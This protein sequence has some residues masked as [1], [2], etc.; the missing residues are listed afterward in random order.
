[1]DSNN[2]NSFLKNENT[3]V[4]T[5]LND[6]INYFKEKLLKKSV[7]DEK[8]KILLYLYKDVN[9]SNFQ[10]LYEIEAI[11]DTGATKSCLPTTVLN[12]LYKECCAQTTV[13]YANNKS[14][15]KNVYRCYYWLPETKKMCFLVINVDSFLININLINKMN[16]HINNGDILS[17]TLCGFDFKTNIKTFMLFSFFKHLFN[18]YYILDNGGDIPKSEVEKFYLKNKELYLQIIFQITK[19][20]FVER[21]FLNNLNNYYKNHNLYKMFSTTLKI[22]QII[23][24]YFNMIIL[25]E[26]VIDNQNIFIRS[27]AIIYMKSNYIVHDVIL[28]K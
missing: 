22:P 27:D 6:E 21:E 17:M 12:S 23:I 24:D 11:L 8:I 7:T 15:L 5:T 2:I 16:L 14:E 20:N 26:V 3:Y 1:L 10:S 4:M 9:I 25:N 18:E 19:N 28:D 13:S